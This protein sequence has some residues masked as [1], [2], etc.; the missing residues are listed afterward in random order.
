MT[1]HRFRQAI[2]VVTPVVLAISA[3]GA[4]EAQVAATFEEVVAPGDH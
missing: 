2:L 1:F 3:A 4:I